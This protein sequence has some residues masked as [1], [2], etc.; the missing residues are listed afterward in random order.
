MPS[1]EFRSDEEMLSVVHRRAEQLHSRHR[2]R[3]RSLVGVGTVAAV[4]A[5]TVV[6]LRWPEDGS[7]VKTVAAGSEATSTTLTR[8]P[9]R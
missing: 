6:V 3:A 5:G 8:Q 2:R 9:L 7:T 4:V 1:T